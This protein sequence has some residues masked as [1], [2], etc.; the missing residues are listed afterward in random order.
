MYQISLDQY[1]ENHM[2]ITWSEVLLLE[3]PC[4]LNDAQ[5]LNLPLQSC[6]SVKG[7]DH[8]GD[9]T[10]LAGRFFFLLRKD[11]CFMLPY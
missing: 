5:N 10:P 6:V 1:F 7:F 2:L 4:F 9:M 3:I 11:F 8:G